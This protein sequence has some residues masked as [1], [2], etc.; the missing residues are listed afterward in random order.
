MFF[1]IERKEEEGEIEEIKIVCL[2][3]NS[4]ANARDSPLVKRVQG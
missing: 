2:V 3:S 1:S 4:G